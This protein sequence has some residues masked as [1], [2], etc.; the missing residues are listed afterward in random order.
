M[1]E[2][3]G[4]PQTPLSWIIFCHFW[5]TRNSRIWLYLKIL[6]ANIRTFWIIPI[7]CKEPFDIVLLKCDSF[8]SV[9]LWHM[10]GHSWTQEKLNSCL[11]C[12]RIWIYFVS[13]HYL[14]LWGSCVNY[15]SR[16]VNS[17]NSSRKKNI[18]EKYGKS[19]K[20]QKNIDDHCHLSIR[21]LTSYLIYFSMQ[22]YL[23]TI[24]TI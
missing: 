19:K 6:A 10:T 5:G 4:I 7:T 12:K 3:G 22:N 13:Q 15:N 2:S 16:Q 21:S 14:Y 23:K 8:W 17:T 24:G 18:Q 1:L 11:P 20:Q 9:W